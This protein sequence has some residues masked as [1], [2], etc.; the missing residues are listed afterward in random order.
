MSITEPRSVT[1][2]KPRWP[3]WFEPTRRPPFEG[4]S[5]KKKAWAWLATQ[6]AVYMRR[7]YDRETMDP[8]LASEWVEWMGYVATGN[9]A[10]ATKAPDGSEWGITTTWS[11]R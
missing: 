5:R 9:V 3:D 6:I 1:R 11:L 2:Y 4:F 8:K 10:A 7:T